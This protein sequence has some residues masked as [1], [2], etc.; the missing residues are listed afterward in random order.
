MVG[1]T[2]RWLAP[3]S[4]GCISDPVISDHLIAN[5]TSDLNTDMIIDRY[6]PVQISLKPSE[7]R[8]NRT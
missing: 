4:I 7:V 2:D 8:P 6:A 1:D 3:V 5:L